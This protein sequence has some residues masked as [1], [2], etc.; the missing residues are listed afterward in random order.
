MNINTASVTIIAMLQLT[1]AMDLGRVISSLN[2]LDAADE[3]KIVL[4]S[5]DGKNVLIV[6]FVDVA[7]RLEKAYQELVSNSVPQ[8]KQNNR[9]K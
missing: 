5:L 1:S 9:Y 6:S 8:Q 7:L 2:K 4:A 3:E